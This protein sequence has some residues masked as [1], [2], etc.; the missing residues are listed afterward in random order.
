MNSRLR[1][2]FLNVR[3]LTFL[4]LG[5][6]FLAHPSY[7]KTAREIDAKVDASLSR[8]E[9]EIF[10]AQDMIKRC[11]GV[12]VFP[13]VYKG[14]I[15]IGAEY[16]E[17]ALRINGK[18]VDYYNIISGS[19]GF[20]FGGQVKTIF[21]FFM[22]DS[23]LREFRASSGWKVGVDGSVALISVGAA[24]SIVTMK[25]NEPILAVILDQ[26]GLMYNLTIEGSKINKIV[27]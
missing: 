10:G 20:Q 11:K 17:G 25:T 7:A 14:G 15:G 27:K 4:A 22:E 16:G 24:G 21:L 23:A 2:D 1:K 3:F 8:F 26:K 6:F 12:L 19:I 5:L 9:R 18:N 13:K